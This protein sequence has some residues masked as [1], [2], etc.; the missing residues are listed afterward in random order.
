MKALHAKGQLLIDDN[1][2]GMYCNLEK[3]ME[4]MKDFLNY[5]SSNEI[6]DAKD[7]LYEILQLIHK[8]RSCAIL[9]VDG[10]ESLVLNE[11]SD[12]HNVSP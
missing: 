12:R 11:L 8:A 10:T 1:L 2:M 5:F 9:T 6:E 3:V 4:F 7:S